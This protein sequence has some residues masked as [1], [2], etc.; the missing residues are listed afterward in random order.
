MRTRRLGRSGI[1]IS[2]IALG[3][4][5]T[6]GHSVGEDTTKACVNAAF[7]VGI[8]FVD[9]ADVYALGACE[10]VLGRVLEG[11][12]RKDYVLATKVFF[13]TGP[14][15]ND[16]GLGRKHVRESIE[17]SL[18][19]LRTDYVELYQCHR[20]DPDVPLPELV[21]TMDDLI[22]RGLILHWGVSLWSADRIAEVTVLAEKMGCEGPITNQPLYNMLERQI[23]DAVLPTSTRFG[24]GQILYCPLA[25]GL[26][27]GKYRDGTIPEDSRA[28]DPNSNEFI[29]RRMTEENFAKVAR[30]QTFAD[31]R[32]WP[33]AA[34]ALAWVLRHPGVSSAIIGAT[35][36]DHIRENARV[37]EIELSPTDLETLEQLLT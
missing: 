28:A 33:L 34:L 16:R 25:Q 2:E 17:A 9:T 15:P 31:D 10:E 11:H 6:Y 35:R 20:D 1:Q 22:R 26:L 19:R 18:R 21:R 5:L 13:P 7:D 37:A 4:W 3:S 12:R 24:V 29:Q 14:G 30:L 8:N 32:G 36:P 27:T 23:E